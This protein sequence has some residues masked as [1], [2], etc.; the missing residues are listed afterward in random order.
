MPEVSIIDLTPENI[1]EYGVCGYKDVRK[2]KEL[3]NKIAWFECYYP[4]GLRIKALVA[5]PG[6]YQGM[7]EYIPG[8]HA[9]R[10]VDAEGY[11]FIHCLF[12]GFRKEFKGQG[13]ASKMIGLVLDEARAEDKL[14]VA[15]VT[16]NGSF[17]ANADIFLKL[18]FEPVDSAEP[19]FQLLCK[20]FVEDAKKPQ[21]KPEMDIHLQK[22]EKGLFILRSPQCPYTEK[23]VMEII[24][25]AKSSFQLDPKLID[26]ADAGAAQGSPCPFGTFCI[27]H[28]GTI[29]SHHPISRKRFENIM[30]KK[31]R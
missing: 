19:D 4:L 14:G 27:I 22:Y 9:H 18:G 29:V 31:L 26:L 10:P 28:D 23:N 3:R 15:T 11:L 30:G 20:S 7:I 25:V 16:R 5:E 8:E 1:A 13:F 2:H 24:D 6:G 12:V 17:M 21:F